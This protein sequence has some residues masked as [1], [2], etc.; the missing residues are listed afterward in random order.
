MAKIK[1]RKIQIDH[2]TY[3]WKRAH[4]HVTADGHTQCIEKVVIYL[5]A[6]KK[7]PL[8]LSFKESDNLKFKTDPEK[9]KWCVGYPDDGMIWLYKLPGSGSY[10]SDEQ[11]TMVINL[12]RPAV[13]A[14][15]IRYFLQTGWQPKESTQPYIVEDALK[16]LGIIVLPNGIN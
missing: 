7:S 9:E 6:H 15:L 13:I 16:L 4:L 3:L 1:L 12:N 5:E 2:A 14:E 11:Q 8:Q 10:S